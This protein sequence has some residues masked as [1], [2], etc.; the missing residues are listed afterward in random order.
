[1]QRRETTGIK[2]YSAPPKSEFYKRR[3]DDPV[4]YL[5]TFEQMAR[6]RQIAYETVKLLRTD[7]IN[8]YRKEGVNHY[9]NCKEVCKKYLLTLRAPNYGQVTPKWMQDDAPAET[10]ES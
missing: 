4:A 5:Q 9:A 8:C 2:A 10:A 7:V 6:E 3:P 1:M